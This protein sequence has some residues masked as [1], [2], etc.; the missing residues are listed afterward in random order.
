MY[1]EEIINKFIEC[2]SFQ[3]MKLKDIET[4][5]KKTNPLMTYS[6]VQQLYKQC[7]TETDEIQKVRNK[8][9]NKRVEDN[10]NDFKVFFDWY[11]QE[12]KK[13]TC[14]YCGISQEELN[15]I[16]KKEKILPLKR[17]SPSTN[18]RKRSSGSLEIER[19]D[20][21]GNSYHISNLILA[22]PLCNNAKSNLISEDDWTN[23]F[24]PAMQKYYSKLL[25]EISHK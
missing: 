19:K 14:G 20:S 3:Q 15:I 23:I 10:N 9:T 5:L 21:E 6:D 22:C 25:S 12:S 18:K 1:T 24:V 8:F 7:K 16:F 17:L 13:G 11:K 2:Y 4:E